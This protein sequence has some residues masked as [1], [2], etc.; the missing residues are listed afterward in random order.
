[1]PSH[2]Y[3]TSPYPVDGLKEKYGKRAWDLCSTV[4]GESWESLCAEVQAQVELY[5][6][7]TGGGAV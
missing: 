3:A 1:M 7:F 4:S 6:E 5:R 2:W